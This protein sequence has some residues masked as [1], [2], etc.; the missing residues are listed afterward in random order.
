M[1]E[2]DDTQRFDRLLDA[3]VNKPPLDV[4]PKDEPGEEDLREDEAD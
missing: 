3:M 4:K 1:P 2:T